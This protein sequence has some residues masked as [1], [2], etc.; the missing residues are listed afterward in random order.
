MRLNFFCTSQHVCWYKTTRSSVK[1]WWNQNLWPSQSHGGFP[2]TLR[3]WTLHVED[4]VVFSV[5]RPFRRKNFLL[6]VYLPSPE[7]RVVSWSRDHLTKIHLQQLNVSLED[8]RQ[9]TKC[10]TKPAC[11]FTCCLSDAGSAVWSGV[12]LYDDCE[13]HDA[14]QSLTAAGLSETLQTKGSIDWLNNQ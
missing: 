11:C 13:T 14:F 12:S 3:H 6:F 10:P 8:V 7:N 2:E 1:K 4:S 9:Q 5:L